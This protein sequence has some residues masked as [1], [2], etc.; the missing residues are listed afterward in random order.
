[1]SSPSCAISPTARPE[2]DHAV[3]LV[4]YGSE[5]DSE[6]DGERSNG[7]SYDYWIIKNSWGE[8][9]G[10]DGYYR[11]VK[12]VNHCGVANFVVHSTVKAIE[13]ESDST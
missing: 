1:M 10:E 2:V 6:A 8:A 4:G 5:A 9:W 11:M 7:T 13:H 12:G 3:L